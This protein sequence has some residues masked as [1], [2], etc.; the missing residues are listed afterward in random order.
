VLGVS[1]ETLVEVAHRLWG[2]S[3]TAHRDRL[4]KL[5]VEPLLKADPTDGPRRVQA[6]RGYATR[7]LMEELRSALKAMP[8]RTKTRRAPRRR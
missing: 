3:L 5:R 8:K 4:V 6:I 1:P 7:D 2:R